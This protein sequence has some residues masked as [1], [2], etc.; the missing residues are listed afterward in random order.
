VVECA[1]LYKGTD[2]GPGWAL[3][4][5]LGEMPSHMEKEDMVG[6]THHGASTASSLKLRGPTPCVLSLSVVPP[7]SISVS[8]P[9]LT[10]STGEGEAHTLQILITIVSTMPQR[11]YL[12][13]PHSNDYLTCTQRSCNRWALCIPCPKHT[14]L[15][16]ASHHNRCL[17]HP[18]S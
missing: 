4:W 11:A 16:F 10:T 13:E 18:D 17:F 2:P 15:L 8:L 9:F 12:C 1:A 3:Q 7:Q 14:S 6:G 5:G